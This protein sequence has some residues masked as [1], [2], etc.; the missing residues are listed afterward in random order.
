M[1]ILRLLNER[2]H[3]AACISPD[4]H[5]ERTAATPASFASIP[6]VLRHK[7]ENVQVVLDPP[8]A[9]L[10]EEDLS[11]GTVYVIESVLAFISS[12]SGRG[13]QVEYPFITLHAISRADSGPCIY[14]QLDEPS[15]QDDIDGEASDVS[16]ELRELKF[17]PESASS[18]D[19]LF[20]A[21]SLCASLH[22]DP[23]S[24][25]D[26][27]DMGMD[28]DDDAFVDADV[29]AVQALVAQG[30]DSEPDL[31]ETGRVRS[32]FVNDTRFKPY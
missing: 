30:V 20:E 3:S 13:F 27:D 7:E 22:P 2:Q 15:P 32:D 9:E 31:S 5:R 16:N 14:C 1:E 29:E 24:S 4:E 8:V 11:K 18:L 17:I 10:S 25:G 6:P 19:A 12:S 21:L 23:A 28:G 26:D